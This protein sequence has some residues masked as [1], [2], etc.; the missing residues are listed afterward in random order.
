MGGPE[1]VRRVK[2]SDSSSGLISR[3]GYHKALAEYLARES[4]KFHGNPTRLEIE[5][6]TIPPGRFNVPGLRL[7]VVP[8]APGLP[9]LYETKADRW[10]G[11]SDIASLSGSKGHQ[12]LQPV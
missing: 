1:Y 4:E 8:A 2:V 5:S 9:W 6:T 11:T 10:C 7:A 3:P 12:C